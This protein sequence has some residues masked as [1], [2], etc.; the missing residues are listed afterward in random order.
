VVS[1]LYFVVCLALTYRV[2]RRRDIGR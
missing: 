1:G 2:L